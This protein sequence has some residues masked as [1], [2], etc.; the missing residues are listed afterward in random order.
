MQETPDKGPIRHL[1][2]Q[3]VK[4]DKGHNLVFIAN[5]THQLHK[6]LENDNIDKVLSN[7]LWTNPTV[8]DKQKTCM[9]KLQTRQYMGHAQKQIFFG[10][11]AYPS[12]Y[13]Q[14]IRCGYMA[15]CILKCNQQHIHA[16]ITKRHNK[17]VWEIR[18]LVLS[19]IISRRY[20]LMNAR[21]HNE[22]PQ[23]NTMPIWLLP[24][25]CSTQR[26][27]CKAKLKHDISCII[28]YPYNHPPL[29]APTPK[30]TIQFNEFTYYNDKFIA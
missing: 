18:K 13:L 19:T 23:E 12:P 29:E 4:H 21:T 26:C 3:I 10:R 16:L 2:K 17:V 14:L 25:T 20:T 22:P 11:E 27:H 6:W 8:T 7:E 9:I 30:L 28:G 1:G 24:C 15:P 5:Q